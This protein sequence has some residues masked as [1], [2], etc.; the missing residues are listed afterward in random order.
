MID[1]NLKRVNKAYS[2]YCPEFAKTHLAPG[3]IERD[4]KAIFPAEQLK[5]MADLGFMGMMVPR[6]MGGSGIDTCSY[7]IA[8]EEIAAVEHPPP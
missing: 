6:K 4:D 7:V 3:V 2:G 1:F 5:I 8:L